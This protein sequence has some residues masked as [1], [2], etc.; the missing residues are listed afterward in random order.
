MAG[1]KGK[2]LVQPRHATAEAS[3]APALEPQKGIKS[4]RLVF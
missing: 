3:A 2:N 4:R 1:T